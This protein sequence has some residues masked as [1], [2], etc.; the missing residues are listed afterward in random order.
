MSWLRRKKQGSVVI[1]SI[2]NVTNG[3]LN[4]CPG[5]IT[6]TTVVKSKKQKS[7]KSKQNR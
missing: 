6:I 3:C 5:N 2:S 1:G 4:I 7:K